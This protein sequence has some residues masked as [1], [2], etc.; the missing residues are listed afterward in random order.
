MAIHHYKNWLT[1]T[2]LPKTYGVWSW[3]GCKWYMI[4]N[5]ISYHLKIKI[6]VITFCRFFTDGRPT[7]LPNVAKIKNECKNKIIQ[8][9]FP[10]ESGYRNG[11]KP[12]FS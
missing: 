4:F 5:I 9:L 10:T 3:C 2:L 6:S 12:I 8:S 11:Y 1:F 7:L